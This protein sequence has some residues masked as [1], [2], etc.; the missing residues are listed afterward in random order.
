[1]SPPDP[2]RRHREQDGQILT[3][4]AGVRVGVTMEDDRLTAEAITEIAGLI[5]DVTRAKQRL[6]SARTAL[7]S[8]L[9]RAEM[10]AE[11]AGRN[12]ADLS[13]DTRLRSTTDAS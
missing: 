12:H 8:A 5:A 4:D 7:R 6:E 1:M 9:T 11:F 10:R 3:R 2:L 13:T